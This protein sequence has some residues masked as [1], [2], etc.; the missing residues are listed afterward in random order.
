[1][2][3]VTKL[4]SERTKA[5][6]A[7]HR[8]VFGVGMTDRAD[9]RAAAGIELLLMATDTR[10]VTAAARKADLCCVRLALVTQK[11]GHS[12]VRLTAVIELRVI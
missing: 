6:K 3:C 5:R 8:A 1:M 12:R 11:A 2:T 7:F 10:R 4:T 9:R